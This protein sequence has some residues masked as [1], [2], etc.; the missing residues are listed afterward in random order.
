MTDQQK[1][2]WD[3]IGVFDTE[4][5]LPHV[6]LV[7][8][9]AEYLYQHHLTSGF[10]ANLRTRDVDFLYPNIN[11]PKG[12]EINIVQGMREKG[13]I[14]TEDYI[15]GVGKFVKED[16]LE[17]EFLTRILGNGQS[18]NKIPSLN[19][20]AEG[21]RA[22]NMLAKYPL[23]L[24]FDDLIITVPEPEAY[25]LQKLLSNP[26]R[27]PEYKKD[28]DIQAVRVLLAHVD[29]GRVQ[30]IFSEMSRKERKIVSEVK[31]RCFIDF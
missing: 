21:L 2:F 29:N 4:G 13:F 12:N 20:K 27:T 28:K 6:M 24:N 17:L 9:W 15:S 10:E 23:A 16:L 25:I 26:K 30:Q 1:A 11:R 14:Y 5:L 18:I 31:A 19:I 22:I 3:L 8:S 7:G